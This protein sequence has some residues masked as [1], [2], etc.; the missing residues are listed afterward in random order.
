MLPVLSDCKALRCASILSYPF[1]DGSQMSLCIF[2]H[3]KHVL[4]SAVFC[5]FVFQM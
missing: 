1:K 5:S 2:I 4:G 3:N